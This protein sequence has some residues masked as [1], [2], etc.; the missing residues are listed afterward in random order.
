[1]SHFPCDSHDVYGPS[2]HIRCSWTS[3]I[4][5]SKESK[6]HLKCYQD[7]HFF[8]KYQNLGCDM[9]TVAIYLFK[10]YAHTT[11]SLELCYKPFSILQRVIKNK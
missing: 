10:R 8:S 6:S 9:F 11:T 1:M 4:Y 7:Y 5:N 2:I 3:N